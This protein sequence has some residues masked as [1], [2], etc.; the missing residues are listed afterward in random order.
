MPKGYMINFFGFVWLRHCSRL[1]E[2]PKVDSDLKSSG[3]TSISKPSHHNSWLTY[4]GASQV[5]QWKIICLPV[6]ETQ[7]C[8]F[9]P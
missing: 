5:A 6:Q 2:N 4:S 8:K 3:F 1:M 9:D 7:R